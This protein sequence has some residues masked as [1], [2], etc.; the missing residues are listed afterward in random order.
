MNESGKVECHTIPCHAMPC[1]Y[2]TYFG[3]AYFKWEELIPF[4]TFA[5]FASFKIAIHFRSNFAFAQIFINKHRA[6]S[7]VF[8]ECTQC[9]CRQKTNDLLNRTSIVE[10]DYYYYCNE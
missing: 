3:I 1:R 2:L 5:F 4:S 8:R 6:L 7:P 9:Q 10:F